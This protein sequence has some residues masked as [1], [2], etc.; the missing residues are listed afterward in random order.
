MHVRLAGLGA[1]Y[2][3]FARLKA[4]LDAAG[5]FAEARKRALPAFPRAVGIVTSTRAAAL[6]DVLTTLAR[7]WPALRVIVYP[8]PV[9][10]AG[11][12]LEIAAAIRVANARARGRRADRRPRRRLDR[13]PVGVQR[14][15]VAQAV[16]ESALP[17]VSGVGHETDFTICDFVADVRAPTPT[18]AAALVAPDRV[19]FAHRVGEIATRCARAA[20]HGVAMRSQRLDARDPWLVH[21]AARLGRPARTWRRTRAAPRGRRAAPGGAGR[22]RACW[23]AHAARA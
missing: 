8:T 5:W 1:L 11:A 15:G 20:R 23:R 4:K 6:R 9:Q 2:E 19:A 13:G 12:A 22:G 17:V 16:F 21:P 14:G 10:G 7:R 18:G 3:Q